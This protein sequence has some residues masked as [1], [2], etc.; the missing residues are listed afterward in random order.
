MHAGDVRQAEVVGPQEVADLVHEGLA[1]VQLDERALDEDLVDR[2]EDARGAPQRF[3][4][5]SLN[6]ELQQ[7]RPGQ[8]RGLDDAV[9]PAYR[10]P[11]LS[12]SGFAVRDRRQQRRSVVLGGNVE[13]GPALL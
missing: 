13:D 3:E 7:R 8:R 6:V 12:A 10:Y 11:L 4:L 5:E 1:A 2:R 9:E